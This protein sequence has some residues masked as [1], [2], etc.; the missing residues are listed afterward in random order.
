MADLEDDVVDLLEA[1]AGVT[2]LVG[3]GAA[4]RIFPLLVPEGFTNYPAITFQVVSESR[5]PMLSRQNGLMQARVQINCWARTYAG[6]KSLKEAVRNA[7]DGEQT[8]FPSGCF[9]EDGLDSVEPSPDAKP[10]RLYG[11]RI[12]AM[13][14]VAEADP[15]F[16]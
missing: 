15:T 5:Q 8:V 9:I 12:D 7:I 1:S 4:A 14:W 16:A 3:T 11:K 10:G 2:A 13:I 6:A